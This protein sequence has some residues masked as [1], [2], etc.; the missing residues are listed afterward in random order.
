M[1]SLIIIVYVYVPFY[2]LVLSV[3]LDTISWNIQ[4]Y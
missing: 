2:L 1:G 4:D 3:S